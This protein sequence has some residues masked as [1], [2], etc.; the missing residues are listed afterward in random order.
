VTTRTSVL[1]YVID[2]YFGKSVEKAA[3]ASGYT[4]RQLSDWLSGVRNPQKQTIEHLIQ[5]VFVPEFRVV[6]E[7]GDFD[8]DK[9]VLGQLKQ[10]LKGYEKKPGI[11]AFYDSM[12]NLLYVGKAKELLGE[13]YAA[14][15]RDVHVE[16]PKGIKA[17]PLTRVE[18]VRYISA[19]DVGD[20]KWQDF[21]KHVE[22]LLLRISKPPLN[23]NIGFLDRAHTQPKDA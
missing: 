15:R 9:A 4:V 8:S 1:Q 19:Y 20:Y 12:A 11:Y 21:P 23:K 17:K 3:S 22:S 2:E 5:C 7:Y 18:I 13:T 16:F 10:L 6:A 14:I